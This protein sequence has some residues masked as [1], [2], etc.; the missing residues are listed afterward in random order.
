MSA[1]S[2][3]KDLTDPELRVMNEVW[4]A[5]EIEAKSVVANLLDICG[6]NASTTYTLIYRCLKKG[7][8]RRQDPGFIL[9]AIVSREEVQD[10]GTV[11]LVN[12]FFEGSV[13]KLFAALVDRKMVTNDAIARMRAV[14]NNY[15]SMSDASDG[16]EPI[17]KP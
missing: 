6:Y 3:D 16:I 10:R 1:M 9:S 8:L 12:R 7:L 15:E 11:Q 2:V 5:G 14:I 17:E 13:D 4:D